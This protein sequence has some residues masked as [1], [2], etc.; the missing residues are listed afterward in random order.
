MPHR[1]LSFSVDRVSDR[2]DISDMRT[3]RHGWRSWPNA[4]VV[5]AVLLVSPATLAAAPSADSASAQVLF[6][7][8]KKL[9]ADGKFAEAC[10]KLEESQRLDPTSGTLINLADCYEQQGLT[11]TAWAAF[12]DAATAANRAGN[13][14]R[15]KEARDRAAALAPRLSKIVITVTGGDKIERIEVKRDSTTIGKAQWGVGM[16]ADQGLHTVT[17]TAPGRKTWAKDVIVKGAGDTVTVQVPELEL[18]DSTTIPESSGGGLSG[19]KVGALAA[20]GVG[21]VGVVVG[22]IFGLKAISKNNDSATYCDPLC[23]DQAGLDVKADAMHASN[24][25]TV[26]FVVGVAGLGGAALLWFTDRP[27]QSTTPQVGLGPLGI[28]VKGAW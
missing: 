4:G 24:I 25:S 19:Q 6:D 21:L 23:H 14:K 15:E 9:M 2:L 17:V 13:P 12:L 22:S 27:E 5:S 28:V 16:P 7:E 18:G 8:G 11:A 10:P 20:G 1:T 3:H 26:A